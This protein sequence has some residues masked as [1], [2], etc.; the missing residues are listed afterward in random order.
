MKGMD[1]FAS[2]ARGLLAAKLAGPVAAA[3]AGTAIANSVSFA[4]TA[5]SECDLSRVSGST[6]DGSEVPR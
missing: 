5:E 4:G 2:T 1:E 6:W 3:V